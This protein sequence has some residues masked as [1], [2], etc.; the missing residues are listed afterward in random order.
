MGNERRN[1]KIDQC[2]IHQSV[3][4][5]LTSNVDNPRLPDDIGVELAKYRASA[6][7]NNW[8]TDNAQYLR[9]FAFDGV[10]DTWY[11][12][13][14]RRGASQQLLAWIEILQSYLQFKHDTPSCVQLWRWATHEHLDQ[15]STAK[16][17]AHLNI[18]LEGDVLHIGDNYSTTKK[19]FDKL[20]EN[21]IH[22]KSI[23]PPETVRRKTLKIIHGF[24]KKT[25]KNNKSI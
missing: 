19:A 1:I 20:F 4:Y 3:A 17:L 5:C 14:R 16:Q 13:Q 8:L 15:K 7:L 11:V 24:S 23:H 6:T 10:L 12:H 9:L 18:R 21:H 22:T 2:A 25:Y